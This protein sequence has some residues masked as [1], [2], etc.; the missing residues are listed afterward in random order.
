MEV[1]LDVRGAS[2]FIYVTLLRNSAP[3]VNPDWSSL[4]S[5]SSQTQPAL[6][7]AAV[8]CWWGSGQMNHAR[9]HTSTPLMQYLCLLP[10]VRAG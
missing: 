6:Q 8:W 3:N 4:A 9:S 5:G 10:S 2:H 7:I 1:L